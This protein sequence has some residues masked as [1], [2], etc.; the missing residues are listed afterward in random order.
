MRFRDKVRFSRQPVVIYEIIPPSK[1]SAEDL[2]VY[3]DKL[4][5]LLSRTHVDAI[6]IP[7]VRD[8][9]TRGA[10]PV[11][12]IPKTEPRVFGAVIQQTIGIEAIVNR[13]VVYTNRANQ[14]DWLLKTFKD[15]RIENLVLVGGESSKLKYPG[16]SVTE[17]ADII[18]KYLNRGFR[19]EEGGEPTPLPDRTDY[20]CG[21][22]TIPSRRKPD[23][24]RD[25]P[26]RLIEKS[27]HGIEFF[28]SQVIYEAESAKKLLKDY[29]QCCVEEKI[30]PKR[31]FL[32]FAPAS[33]R[34]D[35]EF[36]KWLGVEIPQD[37]ES[38]LLKDLKRISERSLEVSCHVLKEIL[39]FTD[40]EGIGVPLGLNV[41]HIMN[42]NFE[43]SIEMIQDLSKLYR[44][45]CIQE[46]LLHDRRVFMPKRHLSQI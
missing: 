44:S 15:Y 2:R 38:Y 21:G 23:P 10:R 14:Q 39:D 20:F 4:S 46:A 22:I 43:I 16:P 34:K 28:T 13:C 1:E 17:T 3:S 26:N 42:H 18:T 37:V 25:E 29:Y 11:K 9:T 45:F 12:A 7:E 33:S 5:S 19:K 27:K 6:N 32:S 31:I 36:L 30:E 35:I 8:E 41:E 24:Q 40:R